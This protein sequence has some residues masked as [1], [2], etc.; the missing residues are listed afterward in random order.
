MQRSA[1]NPHLIVPAAGPKAPKRCKVCHTPIVGEGYSNRGRL[2]CCERCYFRDIFLGDV[3]KNI[4]GA[5]LATIEALVEA[6]E[7]R[8]REVGDHSFRVTQFTM[9]LAAQMGIK[10]R[11]LVPIYCGSLLHDVGK[12][13]IPDAILLK[14]G[15][16]TGEERRIIETHPEIGY[17]IIGPFGYLSEAAEIVYTHHEHFD[18]SG[19]PRKLHGERIPLGARIFA[20]CDTL[21][22][23]TVDRPYRKALPYGAAVDHIVSASGSLFDPFVVEHFVAAEE[24]LRNYVARLLFQGDLRGEGLN[25]NG[26]GALTKHETARG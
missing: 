3:L 22:A 8:E 10:G 15:P 14:Q 23:F 20:V 5:Y 13:G 1:R 12:I 18:G 17:R 11:N 2:Y 19:Y 7:A 24:Q 26:L 16:L 21:D 4:E 9:V 25:C 6:I